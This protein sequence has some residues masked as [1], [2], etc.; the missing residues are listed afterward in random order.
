M[1]K[2][3]TLLELMVVA[4]IIALLS[5]IVYS[6]VI[7]AKDSAKGT[8]S[9]SNLRQLLSADHLYRSDNDGRL[10]PLSVHAD[11]RMFEPVTGKR[12]GSTVQSLRGGSPV[13]SDL[14]SVSLVPLYG[15]SSQLDLVVHPEVW[16]GSQSP[17]YVAPYHGRG[18]IGYVDGHARLEQFL[19][20]PGGDVVVGIVRG[21]GL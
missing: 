4:A 8:V 13:E 1:R 2:A 18:A 17:F 6:S 21:G 11:R 15:S 12:Y 14:T 19:R 16:H 20:C 9:L 3:F 5:A 7:S 10:T